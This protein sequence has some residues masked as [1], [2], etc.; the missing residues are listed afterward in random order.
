MSP[1][2][3]ALRMVGRAEPL[4]ELADGLRRS[5]DGESTAFLIR[6]EAGIG[7]TR[8]MQEFISATRESDDA[9]IATAQCV[10]LGPVGAP[11]APVRM[12]VR[13][14]CD[15]VGAAAMREAAGGP[16]GIA[17]LAAV[18]PEIADGN[19]Q[20]PADRGD[21]LTETLE[22]VVEEL[23]RSHHLILCWE[24]IHWADA[25]TLAA[26]RVLATTLRASRL[27]VVMTCRTDASGQDASIRESLGELARTRRVEVIELARLGRDGVA[28]H[29]AQILGREPRLD[30]LDVLT[31]RSEGVPF[32]VEELLSVSQ[33]SLPAT[34]RELLLTGYLSL[35]PAAAAVVRT[36]AVGGVHVTD[37]VL[38]TAW[39]GDESDLDAGVR[40]AVSARVLQPRDGGYAFRHALIRE[41]VADELLPAEKQS[42]HRAYARA[43]HEASRGDPA[44]AAPAAVHWHAAGDLAEAFDATVTALRS[45]RDAHAHETAGRLGV[46]LLE[47]W[48]GVDD[49]ELRAQSSR[50]DLQAETAR[51]L[52]AGE[53]VQACLE[54]ITSALD[55]APP[56]DLH[57]RLPLM[58]TALYAYQAAGS[59]E[60]ISAVVKEA[61]SILATTPGPEH[62]AM[63]VRF[64]AWRVAGGLGAS[65]RAECDRIVSMAE[66]VGDPELIAE[67]LMG[68]SRA[69][70]AAGSYFDAIADLERTLQVAP[71][72][73]A[74]RAPA[75]NNL[76]CALAFTQQQ[77]R[78]LDVGTQ[79]VDDILQAG[80]ERSGTLLLVNLGALMTAC[81]RLDDGIR[82]MRR[83]VQL[84][85]GECVGIALASASAEGLG[86]LWNDD[87][88]WDARMRGLGEDE[89]ARV[90]AELQNLCMWRQP[91]VDDIVRRARAAQPAKREAIL[92]EGLR[93][94]EFLE[95]DAAQA[96]P[97]EI[98]CFAVSAAMLLDACAAAGTSVEP[99]RWT[100]VERITA[101]LTDQGTFHVEAAMVRAFAARSGPPMVRAQLWE[102]AT[103]AHPHG[104]WRQGFHLSRLMWAEALLDAGNRD[105][106]IALLK[107]LAEEAVHDDVRLV[108]RWARE[109]LTRIGPRGEDSAAEGIA[110]LSPRESQV[111][112][113]IAE[114]LSNREIGER[115]YIS[116]KTASVHVSAIL[117]KL[118]ASNRAEAAAYFATAALDA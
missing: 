85:R 117:A 55:E 68:R 95:T 6:G 10:D 99:Q 62:D 114:G 98:S 60:D 40:D 18:V 83:A 90:D 3:G 118:G 46:R 23:S 52:F 101:A 100:A 97:G 36:A 92:V 56:G 35:A 102:Q 17:A 32:F 89:R 103:A 15:A 72:G 71:D 78:A 2:P 20:L 34:L 27:T 115:L 7:K 1:R 111:L 26:L 87:P 9:V 38:R 61:E 81:G 84:A 76:V 110:E 48:D 19:A 44:S 41:A 45:A 57:V 105:A 39:G 22:R 14:V 73:T 109:L 4:A 75:A 30:E 5:A 107:A 42:T 16:V 104:A 53:R 24:D 69:L 66:R 21:Y 51:D 86:L 49:P 116:H 37:T 59:V 79:A 96:S 82:A 50:T 74:V 31:E 112:A 11:L 63:R 80:R 28:D 43:L 108:A 58:S 64:A 8:L 77:E 113:L 67:A 12:I 25:G 54:L 70:I 88:T 91:M 29:A 13:Q 106:A 65:E 47:L 94:L 33:G 93:L